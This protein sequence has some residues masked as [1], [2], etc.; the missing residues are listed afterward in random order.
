MFTILFFHK[1]KIPEYLPEDMEKEVRILKKSKTKLD[2]LKK[3]YDFISKNFRGNKNYFFLKI[4]RVFKKDVFDLWKYKFKDKFL[5]CTQQN[6]LLR[7]LLIKSGK[8]QEK[9]IGLVN[10]FQLPWSVHQ[11]LTVNIGKKWINVDVWYSYKKLTLG[12]HIKRFFNIGKT[13]F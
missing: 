3:A 5:H 12:K 6:F 11:Y 1:G 2:C 13:V 10:I 8:F 4:E 9:D 7:I